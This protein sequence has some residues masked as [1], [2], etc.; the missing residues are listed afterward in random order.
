MNIKFKVDLNI[1]EATRTYSGIVYRFD[2]SHKF[3]FCRRYVEIETLIHLKNAILDN[4]GNNRISAVGN[5]K[6]S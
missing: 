5:C 4:P 3:C 1:K 2:H 6:Y